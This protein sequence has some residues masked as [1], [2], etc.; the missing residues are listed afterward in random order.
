MI[1][2]S[3]ANYDIAKMRSDSIQKVNR[4]IFDVE[5][6]SVVGLLWALKER[7]FALPL[8]KSLANSSTS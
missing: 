1:T 5:K 7:P 8:R 6:N 3:R 4:S 2:N